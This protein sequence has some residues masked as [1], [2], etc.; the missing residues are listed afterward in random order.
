LVTHIY[1]IVVSNI[2]S[3]VRPSLATVSLIMSEHNVGKP[4]DYRHINHCLSRYI[5]TQVFAEYELIGPLLSLVPNPKIIW[6]PFP[7]IVLDALHILKEP[8]I[9]DD[10]PILYYFLQSKHKNVVLRYVFMAFT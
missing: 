6:V 2:V 3:I 5:P 4:N 8:Q 9:L 10:Y 1:S 7:T